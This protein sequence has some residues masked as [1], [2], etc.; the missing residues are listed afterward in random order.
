MIVSNCPRCNEQL[1]IPTGEFPDDAYAQCPWCRETF[2][3]SD[4]LTSL[5][6]MLEI[7]SADGQPIAAMQPVVASGLGGGVLAPGM[8]A[9]ATGEPGRTESIDRNAGEFDFDHPASAGTVV[10]EDIPDSIEFDQA[11][12]E[13]LDATVRNETVMEETISDETWN[14]E[15]S[16][17]QVEEDAFPGIKDAD[18]TWDGGQVA[19]PVAAMKVSPRRSMQKKG[20][21]IKTV[22]MIV[23]G[24]L[25][26]FPVAGRASVGDRPPPSRSGFLAV[27]WTRQFQSQ[28]G[29]GSTCRSI[30]S[31]FINARE[32]FRTP[33]EF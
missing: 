13:D 27:R 14:E 26:A 9:I 29:R 31:V 25:A 24:G 4:V 21:T 20:S 8:P 28:I 2:P 1:R 5:P 10:G 23:L 6:P 30:R 19:A 16:V 18:D 15:P 12:D 11:P 3:L 7:L 32:A 22:I 33:V 17:S